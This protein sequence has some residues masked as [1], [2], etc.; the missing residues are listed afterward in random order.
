MLFAKNGEKKHLFQDL[1]AG[2]FSIYAI[3]WLGIRTSWMNSHYKVEFSFLWR[4]SVHNIVKSREESVQCKISIRFQHASQVDRRD[5]SLYLV[6]KENKLLKLNNVMWSKSKMDFPVCNSRYSKVEGDT[7]IEFR[8][9]VKL[10]SSLSVCGL[11]IP[12]TWLQS[13]LWRSPVTG[14]L[15]YRSYPVVWTWQSLPPAKAWWRHYLRLHLDMLDI[16]QPL[17]CAKPLPLHGLNGPKWDSLCKWLDLA[18][19]KYLAIYLLH[20]GIEIGPLSRPRL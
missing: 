3:G 7:P 15:Q 20:S 13:L 4:I 11:N 18:K 17:L 2:R 10:F 16:W 5:G 14:G 6:F 19:I 12:G 8:Y 1:R 9:L